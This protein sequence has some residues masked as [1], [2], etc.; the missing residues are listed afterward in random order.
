MRPSLADLTLIPILFM[1]SM[2]FS[3]MNCMNSKA[4]SKKAFLCFFF[5]T[6][7]KIYQV[8]WVLEVFADDGYGGGAWE[9]VHHVHNY[10]GHA[11]LSS[12]MQF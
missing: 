4:F 11:S 7:L 10:K 8:S 1:S 9:Q 3:P 2:L 6:Y 5:S 12:E